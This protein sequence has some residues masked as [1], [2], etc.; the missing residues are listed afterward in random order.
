MDFGN[1]KLGTKLISAFI[2]V[3]SIG[4]IV[5]GIGIRNMSQ[6]NDNDERAYRFDLVGLNLAQDANVNMLSV[7]RSLRD[8]ILASDAERRAEFLA[9]SE[10]NLAQ[11]RENL[12]KARPLVVT[13]QGKATFAELDQ[14]WQDYAQAFHDMQG[15]TSAASLTDHSELTEYLFSDFRPKSNKISNL[16]SALVAVKKKD[17]K[18]SADSNQTLYL[19]SRT[20]MIALVVFSV[21]GD[22][23]QAA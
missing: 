22:N 16:L 2:L 15:K 14:S 13:E 5:S 4:A 9:D 21:Y 19:E 3:S 20:L 17:A 11:A 7:S 10:K 1:I 12:D 6:L 8:A 18:E 23:W